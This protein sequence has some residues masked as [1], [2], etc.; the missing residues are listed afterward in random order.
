MKQRLRGIYVPRAR[1]GA[2]WCWSIV[3]TLVAAVR[4]EGCRVGTV[5]ER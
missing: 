2:F 3:K 1:V 4:S 5:D